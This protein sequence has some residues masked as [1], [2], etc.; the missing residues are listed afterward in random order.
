MK[1]DVFIS[2]SS[3]D[4]KVVEGLCGHLESCGIRCFVAYRDIPRGVAWADA[5][6]EALD[7][8]RMMVVVFSNHFNNSVQVNREIEIA[9]EDHKHILTYRLSDAAFRGAKK[10]YLKN[11][12]WIDA[13]PNPEKN[14]SSVADGVA[15][16]LGLKLKTV[17][18]IEQSPKPTHMVAS[19]PQPESKPRS[20]SAPEPTSKPTPRSFP[21]PKKPTF[22][23]WLWALALTPLVLIGLLLHYTK[24]QRY[25]PIAE[26]AHFLAQEQE[27]IRIDQ[28]VE[29]GKGRD[30]VYQV[31]DY[32]NRNGKEGVVFQVSDDGRNG[33]IVCLTEVESQWSSTDE[34]LR[35]IV[36]GANYCSNGQNNQKKIEQIS[37]W[38]DKYPAFG[39]CASH[40]EGWYLPAMDE[41]LT[42][43]LNL[44]VVNY[45]LEAKGAMILD[46]SASYWSSTEDN[47]YPDLQAMLVDMK[48]GYICS[49]IK[50]NPN[51]NVRAVSAF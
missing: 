3:H 23:K 45:M 31:G 19:A 41:L 44:Y 29:D 6:V 22:P 46:E 25:I 9:S 16:L 13:F 33:K 14:F 48:D 24:D 28:M 17:A 1:Y 20:E 8:S 36:T 32:Y 37:E 2:Y 40:G 35:C 39:W 50:S 51:W 43:Q 10:Y 15:K 12:H 5:I 4:Q 42:L 18:K 30:G 49:S 27:Q 7:E 38:R 26:K 21:L 47:N 11:L 34:C